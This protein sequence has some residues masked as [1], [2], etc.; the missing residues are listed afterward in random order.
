VVRE[1]LAESFTAFVLPF[2]A[3]TLQQ[4]C[5]GD[6]LQYAFDGNLHLA[7]GA[8]AGLDKVLYAGQS[9]VDVLHSSQCISGL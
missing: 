4:M 6:L 1:A 8:Y 7:F 2:H 9:S 5:N 3:E